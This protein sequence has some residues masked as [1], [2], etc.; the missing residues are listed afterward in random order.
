MRRRGRRRL[1]RE[2]VSEV[3]TELQQNARAGREKKAQLTD[4]D[5]D[6]VVFPRCS[7]CVSGR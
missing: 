1:W 6:E 2:S 5:V 3:A 7:N 4:E